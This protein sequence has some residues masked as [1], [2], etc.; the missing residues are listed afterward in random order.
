MRSSRRRSVGFAGEVEES[1]L[2]S[3]WPGRPEQRGGVGGESAERLPSDPPG[4]QERASRAPVGC[5]PRTARRAGAPLEARGSGAE[6]SAKEET[7]TQAQPQCE[8]PTEYQIRSPD[9]RTLNL[10]A[11]SPTGR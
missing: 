5:P 11:I 9:E 2:S 1:P 3:P 6:P 8:F 4:A 10:G 7:R